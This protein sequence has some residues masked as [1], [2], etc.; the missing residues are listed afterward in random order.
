MVKKVV[1]TLLIVVLILS[2]SKN[3]VPAAFAQVAF[4]TAQDPAKLIN[5][6]GDGTIEPSDTSIIDK[7]TILAKTMITIFKVV[8]VGV[9][10]M[11]LIVLAMKYMMAAP[12]DKADIKKHAVPYLVGA[13]VLFAASGIL[14]I[15]EKF[16]EGNVNQD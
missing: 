11:M 8:G 3:L 10:V 4:Q 1:I 5:E 14:Q 12:G 13:V 15:L 16:A 2:I 7:T 6:F 9:A